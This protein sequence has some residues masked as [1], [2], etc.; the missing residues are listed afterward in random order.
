MKTDRRRRVIKKLE[1]KKEG[2][3]K[4]KLKRLKRILK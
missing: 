3:E 1:K 2:E 4:N